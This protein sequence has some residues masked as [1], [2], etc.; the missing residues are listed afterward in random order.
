MLEHNAL[1]SL[2]GKN[3]TS[4]ILGLFNSAHSFELSL[5]IFFGHFRP[6]TFRKNLKGCE[7]SRTNV[8]TGGTIFELSLPCPR[9]FEPQLFH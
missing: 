6:S 7:S 8:P 4:K 3:L 2:G 9:F 1:T 5:S